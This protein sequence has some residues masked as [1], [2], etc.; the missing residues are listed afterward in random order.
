MQKIITIVAGGLISVFCSVTTLEAQIYG[1][2]SSVRGFR[3]FQYNVGVGGSPLNN[4]RAY[5]TGVP[6]DLSVPRAMPNPLA[7]SLR[8]PVSPIAKTSNNRSMRIG[9]PFG[10][11]Q[12]QRIGGKMPSLSALASLNP[13]ITPFAKLAGTTSIVEQT[14]KTTGSLGNWRNWALTSLAKPFVAANSLLSA[15]NSQ[16]RQTISALNRQPLSGSSS[17]LQRTT[18]TFSRPNL[19]LGQTRLIAQR[20]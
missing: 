12:D 20:P 13:T 14:H 2:T 1:D 9:L 15:K 17:D 6:D 8:T 5:S 10:Q 7:Y 4:F 3:N 11:I 16:L 18:S 19:G